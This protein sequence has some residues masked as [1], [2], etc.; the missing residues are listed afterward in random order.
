MMCPTP[1]QH[2]QCQ[3]HK[4][5]DKTECKREDKTRSEREDKTE[6]ET[7]DETGGETKALLLASWVDSLN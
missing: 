2:C 4:R 1:E 6:D 5:E 7:E 3:W